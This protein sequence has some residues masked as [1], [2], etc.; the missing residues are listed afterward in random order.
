MLES[1]S[2][3][4]HV[5]VAEE[6]A[7]LNEPGHEHFKERPATVR[8]FLGPQYLNTGG[9]V[10]EG[11]LIRDAVAEVLIDILGDETQIDKPTEYELA[12]F[13]GSIGSGKTTLAAVVLTYLSHWLLCLKDPHQFLGLLKGSKIAIMMMSTKGKQAKD[14]LFGDVKEMITHSPWFKDHPYDR[15]F[16]NEIRFPDA[17]V[18]I[19]PGDSTETTF[20]GYNLIAGIIDEMDSHQVTPTRDYV[21]QGYTTIYGRMSS[22]FDRRGFLLLIGQMKKAE[23]FAARKYKEFSARDDAYAIRMTIWESRG[24][25]YYEQDPDTGMARVFYYDILRKIIVPD[26]IVAQSGDHGLL[27]IPVMYL[28]DFRTD[29]V[30]ALRDL[31]GIPPS[32]EDPFFSMPVK[33]TDAQEAWKKKHPG[34]SNP[35]DRN[36]VMDPEWQAFNSIPRAIH[37]DAAFASGGD[38]YGLAMGHICGSM[39][40]DG[41][42]KPIIEFDALLR[43]TALP[44]SEIS[45]SS[46]RAIVYAIRDRLGFNIVKVTYDGLEGKDNQQQ[47]RKKKFKIEALSVDKTTSPYY[48]LKDAI[49]EDRVLIPPYHVPLRRGSTEDD[50]DIVFRELS[51]LMDLG[52]K[53]DH[54]QPVG[55]K[56]VADAMAGVAETLSTSKRLLKGRQQDG[57]GLVARQQANHRVRSGRHNL[58]HP[59]Y[60]PDPQQ[61]GVAQLRPRLGG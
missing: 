27:K 39:E 9:L 61:N 15:A 8:E 19:I 52:V 3:E 12:L 13:T 34:K 47:L 60:N 57:I 20:E 30:K 5:K 55:S 1:S 2:N 41:E 4:L 32:V 36:G 25:A 59:A 10:S 29:P 28:N 56:D 40:V 50:V 44:G 38:A 45:F 42:L 48:T 21:E 18:W 54:P 35:F 43:L 37:L 49:Y 31:A 22:R 46:V 17:N 7:W 23:G 24:D 58:T 14:V 11:G 6:L 33:I 51:Q 26:A 53:I 16:K